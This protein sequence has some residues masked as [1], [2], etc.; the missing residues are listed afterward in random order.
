MAAL[1]FR[2]SVTSG[3]RAWTARFHTY[4][5]DGSDRAKGSVYHAE[6]HVR[7]FDVVVRSNHISVD[8]G[9]GSGVK[10][11]FRVEERY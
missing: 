3:R 2:T 1:I 11:R 4:T 10:V 6:R 9:T 5:L 8:I 7:D